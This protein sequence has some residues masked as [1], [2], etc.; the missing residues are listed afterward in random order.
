[1]LATSAIGTFV[2]VALTAERTDATKGYLRTTAFVAAVLAA[3]AWALDGSLPAPA[4][5][6]VRAAPSELDGLR[7]ASL[8]ALTV[9]ATLYAILIRRPRPRVAL[10]AAT[11]VAAITTVAA[12]AVGW[13]PA[14]VDAV[15]FAVQLAILSLVTGG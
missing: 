4:D 11:G 9:L 6:H 1:M 13:A 8:A 12:A 14:L 10:A 7:G 15:P 3:L 5:L 2:F